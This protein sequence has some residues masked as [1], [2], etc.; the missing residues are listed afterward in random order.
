MNKKAFRPAI[1]MIE[2]IFALV[3]MGIVMM[4][5]PMLISTATKSG[6][7]AVQQEGINEAASRVNMILGFHWDDA[8]TD[9]NETRLDVILT[10]SGGHTDLN[11][12][13]RTIG[14]GWIVGWRKGTP[15]ESYRN[16]LDGDGNR[17]TA[18]PSGSFDEGD[19]D[20]IDDF[21]GDTIG[22]KLEGTGTEANY[23][24]INAT[25]STT[26]AYISDTPTGAYN[27]S[28]FSFNPLFNPSPALTNSNIKGISV[29]LTSASSSPEELDKTIILRAFSCNIGGYKLEEKDVN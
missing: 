11:E 15:I 1:A 22:L 25:I 5:A 17:Y 2:L 9:D 13:N 18:T 12:V 8:A 24:E 27:S 16:F 28:S 3:I 20:D 10:A 21:D 26:V 4:S 14:S 6:Y 19:K 23:I 29:T 7:V